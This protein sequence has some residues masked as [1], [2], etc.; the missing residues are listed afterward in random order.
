MRSSGKHKTPSVVHFPSHNKTGTGPSARENAS[1]DA[2]RFTWA[3][4]CVLLAYVS[5]IFAFCGTAG[6]LGGHYARMVM[7]GVLVAALV[8]LIIR[9]PHQ[10]DSP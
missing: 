5:A 2:R 8:I 4:T 10:D 3:I 6:E 7:A 9:R 1:A